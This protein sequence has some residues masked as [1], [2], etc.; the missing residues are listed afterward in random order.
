MTLWY[1]RWC[2]IKSAKWCRL[3]QFYGETSATTRRFKEVFANTNCLSSS[4]VTVSVVYNPST[5]MP[6][7]NG[8]TR[9]IANDLEDHWTD[10]TCVNNTLCAGVLLAMGP[11]RRCISGGVMSQ[12]TEDQTKAYPPELD[13][14]N[15]HSS[16]KSRKVYDKHYKGE[17]VTTWHFL[18]VKSY[19]A[20][21]TQYCRRGLREIQHYLNLVGLV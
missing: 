9:R 3:W 5:E 16:L 1:T 19:W 11:T 10:T 2:A 17:Q 12:W 14:Q 15:A 18:A 20:F 7:N 21:I 13:L 4:T 8:C 6:S